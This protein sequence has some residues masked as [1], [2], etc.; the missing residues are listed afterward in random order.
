MRASQVYRDATYVQMG[1]LETGPEAIAAF[2]V[3]GGF[4]AALRDLSI[5]GYVPPQSGE[6]RE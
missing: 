3:D 4:V 2:D 1:I 5:N 6:L